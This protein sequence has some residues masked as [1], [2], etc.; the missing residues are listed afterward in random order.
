ML[1]AATW[2]GPR[3]YHTKGSKSDRERQIS[4]DITSVQ[5]LKK[6]IPMNLSMKQKQT[7]RL[8]EKTSGLPGRAGQRDRV[9]D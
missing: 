1:F 5:N 4:C 8:R 6:M 3:D 7:H 2:D 9:W